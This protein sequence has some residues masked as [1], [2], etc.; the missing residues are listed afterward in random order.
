ME[1][2]NERF[3]YY[4]E[5]DFEDLENKTREELI[6]EIKDA[7]LHEINYW[8]AQTEE[9]YD[10]LER[11]CDKQLK[12][13]KFCEK[14]KQKMYKSRNKIALYILLDICKMLEGKNGLQKD[15]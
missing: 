12:V 15:S 7:Y 10:E 14:Q 11:L 6:K 13:L 2:E 8:M 4:D 1:K 9:L 3:M 5:N